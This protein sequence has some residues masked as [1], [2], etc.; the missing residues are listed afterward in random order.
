[1]NAVTDHPKAKEAK[2]KALAIA[3]KAAAEYEQCHMLTLKHRLRFIHCPAF[4][5]TMA[6][7]IPT[8]RT[9]RAVRVVRVSDAL[10]HPKDKFSKQ[11]GRQVA[12]SK[13]NRGAF[14]DVRIDTHSH[15]VPEALRN[16]VLV[17]Y[18]RV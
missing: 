3:M 17:A 2:E 7:Q 14:I 6:Y 4:G 13:F 11:I 5:V 8:A 10:L 15:S 18:S 9:K 16:M 1:M 12:A